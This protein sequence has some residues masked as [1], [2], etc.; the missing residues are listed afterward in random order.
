MLSLVAYLFIYLFIYLFTTD[1]FSDMTI[2]IM[3]LFCVSQQ[4]Q[5]LIEDWRADLALEAKHAAATGT[6][7]DDAYPGD[8]DGD[9]S[10]VVDSTAVEN[11]LIGAGRAHAQSELLSENRFRS[12]KSY[13][14]VVNDVL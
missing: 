2:D 10:C 9:G 7:S 13:T 12:S 5:L 14:T 6:H 1:F 11:P 3:L 4:L 8:G